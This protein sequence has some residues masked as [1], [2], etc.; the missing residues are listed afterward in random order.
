MHLDYGYEKFSCAVHA[1]AASSNSIKVRLRDAR[2]HLG[3]L[4]DH[5]V[6]DEMRDEFNRLDELINNGIPRNREGTLT[7]AVNEMTEE[8]AVEIAGHIV[9]FN[10]SL[11]FW[12]G[13]NRENPAA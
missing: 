5:H 11:I 4:R 6:P 10:E 12:R 13:K 8:Q 1:L 3:I 7:A 2:Y 9:S